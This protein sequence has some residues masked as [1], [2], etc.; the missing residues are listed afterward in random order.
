MQRDVKVMP[1]NFR[2]CGWNETIVVAK[3]S[4]RT[5]ALFVAPDDYVNTIANDKSN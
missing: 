2:S 3:D 4:A 5:Y 1:V